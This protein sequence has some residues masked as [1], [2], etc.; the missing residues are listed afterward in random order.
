MIMAPIMKELS[1]E[2]A[3]MLGNIFPY[4]QS[5]QL[6]TI[7]DVLQKGIVFENTLDSS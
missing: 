2:K 4:W 3:I 1:L 6:F 5:V 7:I